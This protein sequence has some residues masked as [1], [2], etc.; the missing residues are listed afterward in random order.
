MA[1]FVIDASIAATWC[2]KDEATAYTENLL[3]AVA[4]SL[5][6]IA[7]RLWAYEVRNSALTGVRRK[8]VTQA[9]ADVFVQSLADLRITLIEPVSYDE[10][11]ALAGRHKL[12]VYDAAYLD[13]AVRRQLSIA[14]LDAELIRAAAQLNIT[15][16][17]P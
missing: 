8:R 11:F 12:T 10:I 1:D 13:L 17:R 16:F 2:F 15:V 4:G 9:D 7:P 3:D 5:E 6:A 14:S